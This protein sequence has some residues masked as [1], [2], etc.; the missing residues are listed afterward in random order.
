VADLRA[1][2]GTLG[3]DRIGEPTQA[4]DGLGPHPEAKNNSAPLLRGQAAG[5]YA[6]ASLADD[7]KILGNVSERQASRL[8]QQILCPIRAQLGYRYCLLAVAAVVTSM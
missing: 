6:F 8:A 3:V 1:D 2:R 5:V 4:R 7:W